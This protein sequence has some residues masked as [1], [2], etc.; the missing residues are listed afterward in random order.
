MVLPKPRAW[1]MCV[2]LCL[3]AVLAG[4]CKQDDTERMV[5]LGRKLTA[6][7]EAWTS[8]PDGGVHK[9]WETVR[10]G[11]QETALAG[12]V[13]ARLRWDKKL[14]DAQIQASATAG[15]VEL[16]GKVR[17]PEQRRRAVEL[18]ESTTGVDKVTDALEVASP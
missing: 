9:G 10:N 4:G 3:F 14:A 2:P 12:R 1:R 7:A 18:A 6:H 11:W 5:R 13:T 15:R 17:D 16:K 8:D